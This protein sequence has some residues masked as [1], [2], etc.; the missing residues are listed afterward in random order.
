MWTGNEMQ[1]ETSN[2]MPCE[3]CKYRISHKQNVFMGDPAKVDFKKLKKWLG[4][5]GQ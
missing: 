1:Q 2:H 3:K 5:F 4:A